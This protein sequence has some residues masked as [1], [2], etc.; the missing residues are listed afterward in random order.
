MQDR[1]LLWNILKKR[2]N[3]ELHSQPD[4]LFY[5]DPNQHVHRLHNCIRIFFTVESMLPDWRECD[6]ALTCRYLDEPRHLRLPLYVVAANPEE[7]LR[8]GEDWEAILAAKKHF[9]AFVIG[10]A[11][12]RKREKRVEFFHRLSRYKKVDSAGGALN[13]MGW[14]VPYLPGAK[15]EFLRSY[16]FNIA[17]E[18]AS[19]PGYT[20][21]KLVEPMQARC[22]AIYWGN[23]RVGEEFNTAGFLNYFDFPSEEALIEEIIALDRD[24]TKYLERLRRPNFVNN[25]PNQPYNP[26]RLLDFFERVFSEKIT[27]V[28]QR[29]RW[30]PFGRWLLAKQNRPLPPSL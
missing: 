5:C 28:A 17:F 22:L 25:K 6:Y 20:T 12:P 24:D 29:R 30:F 10:K 19:I 9:C 7:L 1:Q 8:K 16:K 21:E 27:P 14:H 15:M 18:N 4:F 13:N 11:D 2:F 26:D 3:V 23:P